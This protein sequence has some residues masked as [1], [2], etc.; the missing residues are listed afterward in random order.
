MPQSTR[1][2]Q[3]L[4]DADV[5]SANESGCV[6]GGLAQPL[7]F[8]ELRV[9][10]RGG[11]LERRQRGR[12]ELRRRQA[13]TGAELGLDRGRQRRIHLGCG[14]CAQG[15]DIR[16]DCGA[17]RASCDFLG[18][19]RA[20]PVQCR[21]ECPLILVRLERREVEKCGQAVPSPFALQRRRD[22]VAEAAFR[23][24]VLVREQTIV[25]AQVHR[26]PQHDRLVH[27]HRAHGT[28]DRGRDRAGEEHPHVRSP[29]R[30]RDLHRGGYAAGAGCFAVRESVE[31][32]RRTVEIRHQE[33]A[34]I[35]D[36]QRVQP[37]E[38]VATQVSG[39]HLGGQTQVGRPA[40]VHSL[41]PAA[42]HRRHPAARSC[43]VVLPPHRIDVGPGVKQVG[44]QGDLLRGR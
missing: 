21:Q 32:C 11:V 14:R 16:A 29:P 44:I 18:V 30:L 26:S 41:A 13:E 1:K 6:P 15:G 37:D 38:Y 19:A 34:R 25:R 10:Y 42:G 43:P 33:V 23:Q 35:G 22:Q 8:V 24:H 7:K 31:H 39:D 28:R 9:R 2:Y 4:V 12:I 17:L 40:P 27:E 5:V 3:A 36:Q 20:E